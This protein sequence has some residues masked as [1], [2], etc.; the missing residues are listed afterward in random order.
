MQK[1]FED[2]AIKLTNDVPQKY[3]AQSVTRIM[4]KTAI[5][6]IMCFYPF[7]QLNN[8]EKLR[9]NIVPSYVMGSQHCIGREGDFKHFLKFP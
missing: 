6:T 5:W 8:F 4:G 7:P 3:N 2:L 9:A 1:T